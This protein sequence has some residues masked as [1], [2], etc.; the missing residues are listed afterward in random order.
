MIYYVEDDTNIRDL[1]IYALR[2]GGFEAEGFER[3]DEF[4]AAVRRQVPE[5]VLLDIMLPEVDGLEIL[6]ELRNNPA[7]KHIPIMMLTAK[8]TEYDTVCGLDAGA[9]DY[10]AKPFGMME[11]VSR[12]NALLR[13]AGEP[14]ASLQDALTVG[15]ITLSVSAHSVV[16]GGCPVTLTLKEFDLLKALMRHEGQVLS[17]DQLLEDVWGV[18]YAGGTRTVDVHVQ[19]LRQKLSNACPGAES[20]ITT[21]RGV[22]YSIKVPQASA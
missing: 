18:T 13:R 16:V 2:Q 12:V 19:T 11:L 22:G 15:D 10:L 20:L 8:G 4:Y 5:L 9:D 3:A 17:R 14:A 21:V 6:R 7:T 1:T